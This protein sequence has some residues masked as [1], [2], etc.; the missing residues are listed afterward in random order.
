LEFIRIE[1]LEKFLEKQVIPFWEHS[2]TEIKAKEGS[3]YT[4]WAAAEKWD[5]SPTFG[6]GLGEQCSPLKPIFAEVTPAFV[7][8]YAGTA[9][10]FSF[11]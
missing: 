8:E 2:S 1:K 7:S 4:I 11:M 3:A 9:I 10:P 5:S 6:P